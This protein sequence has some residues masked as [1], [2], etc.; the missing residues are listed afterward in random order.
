MILAIALSPDGRTFAAAQPHCGVTVRDLLDGRELTR[1]PYY[2]VTAYTQLEFSPGGDH[3]GVAGVSGL[4]IIRTATGQSVG[5]VYR[6]PGIDDFRFLP[7]RPEVVVASYGC[8]ERFRYVP[9]TAS[10]GE[11]T[12]AVVRRSPID[13][14]PVLAVHPNG[15][16]VA[17]TA[18]KRSGR[19]TVCAVGTTRPVAGRGAP[20]S[21]RGWSFTGRVAVAPGRFAVADAAGV[22]VF[23]WPADP[24]AAVTPRATFPVTTPQP[25]ADTPPLA[26]TPCGTFLLVR[27]ERSRVELRDAATGA[28]RAV[29]K[30]G[31]PRTLAV[32]VSPD[33]L[34]AA[35]AGTLGRVVV[36]DLG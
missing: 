32:A 33:G 18:A 1:S 6:H 36:W 21:Y 24:S 28:V 25:D 13:P 2:G 4:D 9:R 17:L 20:K 16:R 15:S 7:D 14:R 30:W 23:D 8:C 12:P 3:L 10:A 34:V 29:W 19:V 5:R 22:R 11:F 26:L 27:G 31:L 35:A